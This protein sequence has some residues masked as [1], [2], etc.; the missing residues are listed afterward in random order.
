MRQKV[1]G[2]IEL[3]QSEVILVRVEV[4][5]GMNDLLLGAALNVRQWLERTGEVILADTNANLG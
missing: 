2:L 3:H 1:K 4:V 5:L